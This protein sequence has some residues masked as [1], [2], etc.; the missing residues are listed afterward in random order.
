M[1]FDLFEASVRSRAV[2]NRIFLSKKQAAWSELPSHIST[3]Q[4]HQV[5][6]YECLKMGILL[7]ITINDC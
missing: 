5:N 7:H 3:I 1:I 6:D 4:Y 2:K